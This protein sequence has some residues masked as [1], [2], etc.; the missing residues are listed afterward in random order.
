MR[1]AACLQRKSAARTLG[2][3]VAKSY[4]AST[5]PWPMNMLL[6]YTHISRW[7]PHACSLRRLRCW[8]PNN[9][10]FRP[11]NGWPSGLPNACRS[12][13]SRHSCCGGATATPV[14]INA[15][16]LYTNSQHIFVK[17]FPYWFVF[18]F[19]WCVRMTTSEHLPARLYFFFSYTNNIVL[20][21]LTLCFHETLKN[22]G[23]DLISQSKYT[24]IPSRML[25][26]LRFFPRTSL[27]MGTSG[28]SNHGRKERGIQSRSERKALPRACGVYVG[29]D[30]EENS[31]RT[32]E[33]HGSGSNRKGLSWIYQGW[34]Y[35]TQWRQFF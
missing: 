19:L 32:A 21:V 7:A 11:G 31:R 2:C 1:Q 16:V 28:K 5:A 25:S 29:G 35:S 26:L 17:M 15:L 27:G 34:G 20:L 14:K 10:N 13:W 22:L 4:D 3:F 9:C 23:L 18:V 24:S 30:E 8:L 6:S 33:K 12:E